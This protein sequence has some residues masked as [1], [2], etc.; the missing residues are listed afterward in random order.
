MVE[1]FALAVVCLI[2]AERVVALRSIE[3]LLYESILYF[4]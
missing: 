4:S 1:P 2:D 3:A